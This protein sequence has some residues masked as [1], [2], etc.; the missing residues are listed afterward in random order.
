MAEEFMHTAGLSFTVFLLLLFI[1]AARH[2]LM[3]FA[4][5]TGFLADYR[6]LPE[7]LAPLA[8]KLIVGVEILL[9]A[10]LLHHGATSLGIMLAVGL[11]SLYAAAMSINLRRGHRRIACGCG[12]AGQ[13]I[14]WAL[15]VRNLLLVLLVALPALGAGTGPLSAGNV[16]AAISTGLLLWFVYNIIDLLLANAVH[17]DLTAQKP[18][19][20]D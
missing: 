15:V 10:L 9:V 3:D 14:S 19:Q 7:S 11:L 17:V 4:R 16:V 2:K 12:G 18:A 20:Q 13:V 5:F 6:L 1:N 8:A